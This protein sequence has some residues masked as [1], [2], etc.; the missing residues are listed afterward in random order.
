M[1]VLDEGR[2]P[3]LEFLRNL[4]PQV[5][6]LSLALFIGTR[7]DFDTLDW[8]NWAV[9][10]FFFSMVVLVVL[11]IAANAINFSIDYCRSL[12]VLDKAVKQRLGVRRAT[13]QN[14]TSSNNC[15]P[16]PEL[17]AVPPKVGVFILLRIT[18][19]EAA[20]LKWSLLPQLAFAAIVVYALML[21][22]FFSGIFGGASL[23]EL[24][25]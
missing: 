16:P 23:L 20:R 13:P 18:F 12:E 1:Y 10:G 2:K 3:F 21:V 25:R 22:V 4:T 7:L 14:S 24:T 6:L 15:S 8:S 11:S 19:S 17:E 5:A 9:T